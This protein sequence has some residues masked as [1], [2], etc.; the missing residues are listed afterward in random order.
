MASL[1]P[2]LEKASISTELSSANDAAV[3]QKV[4]PWDVEGGYVD[5]KHLRIDYD[6]HI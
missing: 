6:K 1:A 5:A 4:T 2:E 3:E